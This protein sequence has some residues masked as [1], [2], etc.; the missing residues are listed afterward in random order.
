MTPGSFRSRGRRSWPN[1]IDRSFHA[2]GSVA[3][4]AS[5]RVSRAPTLPR[6]AA[7]RFDPRGTP[8]AAKAPSTDGASA[9]Q[10]VLR[11]AVGEVPAGR[12]GG[13]RRDVVKAGGPDPIGGVGPAQTHGTM[14]LT[15]LRGG[16]TGT[17]PGS[18]SLV[19]GTHE[20]QCRVSAPEHRDAVGV[21]G[22]GTDRGAFVGVR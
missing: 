15:C 11:S 2:L 22:G 19:K 4:A 8:S 9:E 3:R 18:A 6:G 5:P 10:T 17:Q 1:G 12:K 21:R 16:S 13:A 7:R 20:R 14:V